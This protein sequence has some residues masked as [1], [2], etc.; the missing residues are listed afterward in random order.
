MFSKS[1]F[2]DIF[3][4]YD[5]IV[6]KQRISTLELIYNEEAKQWNVRTVIDARN[7]YI[8]VF[9]DAQVYVNGIRLNENYI[10]ERN[11]SSDAYSNLFD[12]NQAPLVTRYHIDNLVGVP[13]VTTQ[14]DTKYS[15]VRR[16][17]RPL[18]HRGSAKRSDG[19][20]HADTNL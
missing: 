14:N 6:D 9:G 15:I 5:M 1:A 19:G 3:L 11:V 13:T 20:N 4:Y 7:F 2:N 18:L 17:G 12:L 10:T 8:E 16:T